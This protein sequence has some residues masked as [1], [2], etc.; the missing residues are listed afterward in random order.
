MATALPIADGAPLRPHDQVAFVLTAGG[1]L[2]RRP[3]TL[4]DLRQARGRSKDHLESDLRGNTLVVDA[5]LKGLSSAGLLDDRDESVP[6]TADNGGFRLSDGTVLDA[7]FQIVR[8]STAAGGG[9]PRGAAFSFITRLDAEG[10]AEEWLEIIT[11]TTET[12]RAVAR[13]NQLLEAH[14]SAVERHTMQIAN[15]LGLTGDHRAALLLAARLHDE[16]KRAKRWQRGFSA[17]DE[18]IY[19]K[20]K[21]PVRYSVLLGYRH[22][23]GSLSTA[24]SAAAA[25][26]LPQSFQDLALHLI[27]AHH[28]RARPV[29]DTEGCEDA[30]PFRLAGRA[31][32]VAMRFARLQQQ[33]GPWGLA[34]WECLLRAADQSASAENDASSSASEGGGR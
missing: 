20:T 26:G 33:W 21:G 3:L 1:D 7:G 16:G 12:G 17:P 9:E 6:S 19:G 22:E 15:D 27:A 24:E 32:A 11:R 14:V 30:P 5:R 4:E 23:F 10:E 28:G 13:Q 34:W 31:R 8:R 2:K 29:I 25:S 18:G